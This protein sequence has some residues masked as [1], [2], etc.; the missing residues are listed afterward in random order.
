MNDREYNAIEAIR[1]SDLWVINKTPLHFKSRLEEPQERT[2]AL[3]FGSATHKFILEPESFA[4]EYAIAPEGIDKR[5]KAGKEAW[6]EFLKQSAGKDV[7]TT[8]QFQTI[9]EMNKALKS[10]PEIVELLKGEHETAFV[11]TDEETGEACKVK[12]DCITTRDGKRIIV[13]YK[14]TQ[15]CANGDFERSAKKYGYKFQA[16]MYSEGIEQEYMEACD[17][18]FIAQEK[19][20]PYAA[21]IYYAEADWVKAGKKQFHDLLRLYHR[22][23]EADN[24]PGYE[25]AELIEEDYDI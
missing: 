19:A 4:D 5:T 25:A 11:W 24:W 7:I 13:D 6:A 14:T 23:K 3:I 2:E 1:R 16:G 12:A 17:F 18:V 20:P 10:N 9:L 21:R 8:E 15:S 22:C